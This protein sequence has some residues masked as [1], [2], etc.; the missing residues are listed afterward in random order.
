MT[1]DVVVVTWRSGERVLRCLERLA[2]QHPAERT[3]VV[4]NASHD[5]TVEGVRE[6]FPGVRVLE[7][8]ENRGF[9]AG[10]NAGA[11]AGDGEAIVLV[12][13]DV[14]VL[15]GFMQAILAP[16]CA[17]PRCGMVAGMT[18]IPGTQRVDAFGIELD[19]TLAAYNR[20]RHRT[21]AERP[22]R[23]AMPSGG[24]AAYRRTAFERAGGFDERLFA[25][26]EDVDLGL[27]MRLDGWTAAEAPGARGIHEGGATIGVGSPRQR[28]L[29]GFARG[30]L[31]ARYGVLRGRAAPRALIFEALVV[32]WGLARHRTLVPL[33]ARLSGYRCAH[34]ERLRP[35]LDA[36]D[37][38]IGWRTALSRLRAR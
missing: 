31:L 13:D 38:T 27:R 2:G 25:Y 18:M 17:D 29:F 32:G 37:A 34:G 14:Q 26:G 23:L 8:A 3:F 7:L 21:D 24:L 36:V 33:R 35:P 19:V 22:G 9:G 20:L 10:A 16:L 12:N 4:D 5:G 6:R 11:A 1:A 15:D 30:F 28:E